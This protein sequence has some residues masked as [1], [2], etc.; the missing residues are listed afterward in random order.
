MRN[1][2]CA[3]S[4]ALATALDARAQILV[5]EDFA[6]T[7]ALTDN[8]WI[9]HGGAGVGPPTSN[10]DFVTLGQQFGADEDV[11]RSFSAFTSYETSFASFALRVPSGE[12]VEPGPDG[13]VFLHLR[14]GG[15]EYR[16]RVGLLSPAHG[17]DFGIGVNADAGSIGSGAVWPT[18]LSFDAWYTIVG[19][20]D[21][22]TG[23]SQLWVDPVDESSPR[24]SHVGAS[25]NTLIDSIALRQ[26]D[27]NETP[28]QI[29]DVVVGKSFCDVMP[30]AFDPDFGT[31]LS[32]GPGGDDAMTTVSLGFAFPFPDGTSTNAVDVDSN[33]RIVPQGADTSDFSESV[34]ELLGQTTSIAP[35][36]DDLTP[37]GLGVGDISFRTTVS[38]AVITWHDVVRFGGAD[39]F[40]FQ[41]RLYPD[42]RVV[43]CYDD[44][45][46]LENDAIVGVSEGNGTAD[47]GATDLRV[48]DDTLGVS[49]VYRRFLPGQFNLADGCVALTP[50]SPGWFVADCYAPQPIPGFAVQIAKPVDVTL[51]F[52]PD[53]QGGYEVSKVPASWVDDAGMSPADLGTGLG[54]DALTAVQALGHAFSGP[55]G[56]SWTGVRIDNNGV[57]HDGFGV[58]V[59]GD[60]TPSVPEL[61]LDDAK[62]AV[63]WCDLSS[64]LASLRF[65]TS[66]TMSVITWENV[67]QA[68]EANAFTFQAVLFDDDSFHLNYRDT[69]QWRTDAGAVS[70]DVIIGCSQGGVTT[71]PGESDFAS[72]PLLSAGEP[73]IYEHWDAS[74]YL[75][76][77][78]VELPSIQ[79]R[80]VAVGTPTIGDAINVAVQGF[81]ASGALPTFLIGFETIDVPIDA[82]GVPGGT[83]VPRH[84][85]LVP[86]TLVQGGDA[87]SLPL[88]L[89][90]SLA[91]LLDAYFQGVYFAPENAFGLALTDAVHVYF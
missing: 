62:I 40:S 4:I 42:G 2:L 47:P 49:T 36:W 83:L 15:E 45:V 41:C 88:P 69:S 77:D 64:Q 80:I 10:G 78:L 9:A 72:Y 65:A 67:P 33:G 84:E 39:E 66:A 14:N 6:F 43:F 21:P 81:T 22:V 58:E 37:I 89:I 86:M 34:A 16:M 7:G 74:A 29:D 90:P 85:V 31:G 35:Y 19:T 82:V 50:A 71:G 44:R 63:F 23:E 70:D 56:G 79:P 17:G 30:L 54:D 53:G 8:G 3:A 5:E 61:I 51:R 13:S 20:F 24:V 60:D 25:T 68:G 11:H 27:D 46:P 91:D 18:D 73:T 52:S 55:G 87:F 28:Q 12:T 59:S 26:D 57:V 75:A 32:I 48:V 1:T 76:G 38:V